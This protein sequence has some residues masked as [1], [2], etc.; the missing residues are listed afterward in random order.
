MLF[1]FIGT[2]IGRMLDIA[3]FDVWT[4]FFLFWFLMPSFTSF[5]SHR[6]LSTVATSQNIYSLHIPTHHRHGRVSLCHTR[7]FHAPLS[8]QSYSLP[9]SSAQHLSFSSLSSISSLS[10]ALRAENDIGWGLMERECG[11]DGVAV[12]LVH[13]GLVKKMRERSGRWNKEEELEGRGRGRQMSERE[14]KWQRGGGEDEDN[15]I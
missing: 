5:S 2:N 6:H 9:L 14:R 7:A 15:C 13:R 12:F 3:F 10:A 1:V 11:F 4:I 8:S